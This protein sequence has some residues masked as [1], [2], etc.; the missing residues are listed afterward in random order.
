M[1]VLITKTYFAEYTLEEKQ[2]A[3]VQ[4]NSMLKNALENGYAV[5]Y[6]DS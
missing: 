4:M 5:G 2:M 3:L 6:F 1:T